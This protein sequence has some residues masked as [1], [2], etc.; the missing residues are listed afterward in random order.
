MFSTPKSAQL[1][2]RVSENIHGPYHPEESNPIHVFGYKRNA[3]NLL[4]RFIQ[5]PALK[6]NM[7]LP[8]DVGAETVTEDNF[9]PLIWPQQRGVC[10]CIMTAILLCQASDDLL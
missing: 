6:K 10:P 2:I 1:H 8:E 4:L 5:H 7:R 3:I 9:S